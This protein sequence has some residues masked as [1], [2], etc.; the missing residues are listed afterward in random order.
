[1]KIVSNQTQEKTPL[2][3]VF[4]SLQQDCNHKTNVVKNELHEHKKCL[5]VIYPALTN[6]AMAM[7]MDA[8]RVYIA[9]YNAIVQEENYKIELHNKEVEK[10]LKELTE[11]QKAFREVF[12]KKNKSLK[13]NEF[14]AVATDFNNQYGNIIE[15]RKKQTVKYATELVFQQYLHA[16]QQQLRKRTNVHMK[17]DIVYE[18]PVPA[19]DTNTLYVD[20]LKRNGVKSLQ[21][22]R[23]SIR[24]HRNRLEEAGV[25][26]NYHYL[27]TKK[28][29]KYILNEEILTVFDLKTQNFVNTENQEVTSGKGK[30]F[31]VTTSN[32]VTRTVKNEYKIKENVENNS[33]EKGTPSAAPFNLVFYKNTRSNE[34]NLTGVA[35]DEN[36]KISSKNETLSEK[37]GKLVQHPQ[38]LAENLTLGLYNDYTAIDLRVLNKEAY[39]GTLT[40][41]EFKELVIQDFIKSSAKIW[42]GKNVYC[43]VWKKLI[44][45]MYANWFNA[46]TGQAFNKYLVV[47]ML[48][49]YRWRINH[50]RKW[51]VSHSFNPLF[52]ADYFD[53]SRTDRKEVGFAYTKKSWNKH[54]K[55]QAGKELEKS[56]AAQKTKARKE[57][58]NSSKAVENKVKQFLNGKME[59]ETLYNFVATN[60]PSYLEKLSEITYKVQSQLHKNL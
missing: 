22:T 58:I 43:G 49:E 48:Q 31:T 59:I 46:F 13:T 55:Y 1:M 32:D 36:V 11:V 23:K 12:W 25:F 38:E 52:P 53:L 28:G 44:N 20:T 6:E 35:A 50:A 27:G 7:T 9:A 34:E 33:F 51:F 15:L 4:K 24:N 57:N 5:K 29:V 21:L 41:E 18:A 40:K 47:E 30:V 3:R 39:A 8:Y 42:K 14:N 37:L 10:N 56:R 19:I 2:T 45:T 17:F 26:Q 16:F 60:H 54:L